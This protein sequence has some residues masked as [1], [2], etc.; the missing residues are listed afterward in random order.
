MVG[1]HES[2]TDARPSTAETRRYQVLHDHA[3]TLLDAL[4]HTYVV[5]WRDGKEPLDHD[6]AGP[7]VRT[8]RLIPRSPAAAP[9]SVAFT[10][11]PSVILRFGRWYQQSLPACGCDECDEDPDALVTELRTQVAA[12][13]EGGLWERVRRGP[14]GS[15]SE[16]RLVGPDF[17]V[18]Q[19]ALL[20][21]S[22]ARAARRDGF[23][24]A[25]QWAPWT[26]RPA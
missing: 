24:A 12:L 20:D 10:D 4:A 8:V 26:R 17:R 6:P 2:L 14:T 3:D 7:L 19:R 13:I 11:F 15:W 22:T 1:H 9:L 21:P 5:V 25:V 18:D 16:A 23:A